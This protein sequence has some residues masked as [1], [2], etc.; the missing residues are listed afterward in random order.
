MSRTRLCVITAFVLAAA[1][2]GVM[3]ARHSALGP[4]ARLPHGPDTWKVTM[5]VQGKSGGDA[6]LIT[7]TP[8][9][10]PRQHLVGETYAGE[11]FAARPQDV[12]PAGER[13]TVYWTQ[14]PGAGTVQ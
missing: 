14:R 8:L 7:A 3:A 10:G 13:R 12:P 6:K 1:S 2:A 4:A 9:D 5:L 11:S